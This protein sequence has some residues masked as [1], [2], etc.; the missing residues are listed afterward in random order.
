MDRIKER[1]PD[2]SEENYNFIKDW[3]FAHDQKEI[4]NVLKLLDEDFRDVYYE[5][6]EKYRYE[7]KDMSEYVDEFIEMIEQFDTNELLAG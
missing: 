5:S 2:I 3:L 1:F 7:G 4:D 6:A